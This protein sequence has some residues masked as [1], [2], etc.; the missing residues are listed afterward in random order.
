[1]V[2]VTRQPS[3]QTCHGAKLV[4]L[5]RTLSEEKY[6]AAMRLNGVTG[7]KFK[8]PDRLCF[9]AAFQA[10]HPVNGGANLTNQ[11]VAPRPYVMDSISVDPA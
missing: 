4:R 9:K 11:L 6:G 8:C 1:M 2:V 3:T 10:G 7:P 5:E